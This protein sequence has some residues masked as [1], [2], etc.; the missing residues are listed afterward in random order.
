MK[1]STLMDVQ[2]SRWTLKTFFRKWND[3]K[4]LDMVVVS[5]NDDFIIY[6]KNYIK[7]KTLQIKLYQV[8]F[9]Y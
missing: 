6:K 5:D 2:L 7:V 4:F 3:E 9:L 1:R 8:I